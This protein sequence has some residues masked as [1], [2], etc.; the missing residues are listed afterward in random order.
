VRYAVSGNAVPGVRALRGEHRG[1]RR[2]GMWLQIA[3]V[4]VVA[5]VFLV[6]LVAGLRGGK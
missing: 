5:V 1:G 4:V 6:R 3:F 2:P